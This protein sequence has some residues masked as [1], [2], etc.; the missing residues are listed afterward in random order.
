MRLPP[1]NA[2]R[3]FEAAARSLSFSKAADELAVT[4]AAVSHQIKAL[5]EWLGVALFKRLNRAVMLT[6]EGQAYVMG[7]REG[8]EMIAD[9]TGK[10]KVM[11][12]TR[13]LTVSTLPSFA[14]R[15]LLPRLTRFREQ[16][17]DIDVRL[18]ATDVLTDFNREDMDL[19]IRYGSGNY[20]GLYTEKLLMEDSLFPVCSPCLL[21]GSRPLKEPGDLI[22][23]TLLH[24]DLRIDWETWLTAAGVQGV[25]PR[26]GPSF[27]DS[28]M[29][30]TAAM[31][32]Q[33]IAL[34][35]STLAAEDLAAG[36]LVKPFDVELRA[37]NAYFIVCPQEAL[38]KPRIAA[39]RQWLL[40]EAAT[41]P[42]RF[43]TAPEGLDN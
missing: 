36:R 25:D 28:S 38:D 20:P 23:H 6:D 35:R 4:P 13:A 22:H 14:A 42:G 18:S 11:E 9:A 29:V 30:L 41:D 5:E 34:G 8:L 27:N 40:D 10:L 1:L 21:D 24:D 26:K 43:M 37:S 16:Y 33:G 3:V 15:W 31:A 7:I 19:V 17:P 32:G 2:L 12:T 39:F